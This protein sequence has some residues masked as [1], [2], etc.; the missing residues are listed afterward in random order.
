[1]DE[2]QTLFIT[3]FKK[4]LIFF[5]AL[6]KHIHGHTSPKLKDLRISRQGLCRM[7]SSGMLRHVALVRTDVSK[8]LSASIFRVTRI[9]D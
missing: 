1:M 6:F 9:G 3:K 8:K 5:V 7:V 2:S 4:Y